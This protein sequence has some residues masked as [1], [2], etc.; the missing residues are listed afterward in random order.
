MANNVC[1]IAITG[2]RMNLFDYSNL[3]RKQRADKSAKNREKKD[4]TIKIAEKKLQWA[5]RMT[6]SKSNL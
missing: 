3:V 2:R 6:N 5:N 4:K 1:I